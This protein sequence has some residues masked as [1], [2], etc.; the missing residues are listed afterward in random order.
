MQHG[1]RR[2]V[3]TAF[4]ALKVFHRFYGLFAAGCAD[5]FESPS[6]ARAARVVCILLAVTATSWR[7][8]IGDGSQAPSVLS[9]H[10]LFVGQ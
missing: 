2:R 4:P 5:L 8:E 10:L 6:E 9:L 7:F 1:M 3:L